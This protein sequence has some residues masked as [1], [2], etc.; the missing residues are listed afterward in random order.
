M[1]RPSFIDIHLER[2]EDATSLTLR[3]VWRS[4]ETITQ[5]NIIMPIVTCEIPAVSKDGVDLDIPRSAWNDVE[6]VVKEEF[7]ISLDVAFL[8]LR[9]EDEETPSG[10]Y[11]LRAALSSSEQVDAFIGRLDPLIQ[12]VIERHAQVPTVSA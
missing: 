12:D 5:F 6:K 10:K 11:V 8:E 9:D 4:G 1:E 7:G 2:K 3:H